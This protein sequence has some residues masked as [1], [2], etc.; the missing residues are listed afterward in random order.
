[1]FTTG[2]KVWLFLIALCF[3]LLLLGGRFGGRWGLL[4][5]F[6]LA[7]GVNALIFFLGES[8]ILSHLQARILKGHDSWGLR[9]RI[10]RLCRRLNLKMPHLY[11]M[12]SDTATLFS[13]SFATRRP[14]LCVSSALLRKLS[15][16]ELDAVLTQQLCHLNRMESFGFGVAS[17]L[18]NTLMGVG[19]FLDGLWPP[20]F[21]LDRKQKPFLTLLSPLGWL[22][23]RLS[24]RRGTFFENDRAAAELLQN[25]ELLGETLW[26][27]E[28]LAQARPLRIPP[29][30]S[31]L[32][33]VN[34][35]GFR[36]KNFFLRSHPPLADRLRRL[37]GRPTA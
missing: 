5:G 1:M 19:E 36:Q 28:G 9:D 33:I 31:H 21:L 37:M 29:C 3:S 27:L 8:R 16:D 17:V 34:P 12:E 11:L 22:I 23:V 32:F 13:L 2:T 25:R 30:T 4:L 14:S 10:E 20:N 35:E 15:E 26:R 18:A 6:L 24:I 7:L